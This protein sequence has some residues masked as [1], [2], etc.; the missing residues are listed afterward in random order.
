MG[1]GVAAEVSARRKRLEPGFLDG[2]DEVFVRLGLPTRVP[3]SVISRRVLDA[4]RADKKRRPGDF[5][6]M[7]LPRKLGSVE[8]VEDVTDDEIV[9][10]IDARRGE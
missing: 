10:A 9:A 3:P 8:I 1:M 7:A 5:H 4:L 2:Q 6:T